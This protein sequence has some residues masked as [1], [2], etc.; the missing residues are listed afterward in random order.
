MALSASWLAS[1]RAPYYPV[2]P[3]TGVT[4]HAVV[5]NHAG[6]TNHDVVTNHAVVTY[7]AVCCGRL[8]LARSLLP[9]LGA[10]VPLTD[11]HNQNIGI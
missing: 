1:W 5:T 10:V 7:H 2:S 6:V 9:M 11:S 8:N 4:N 3:T